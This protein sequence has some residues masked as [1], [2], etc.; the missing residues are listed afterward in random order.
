MYIIGL[1][2]GI[3]S[4][5]STVSKILKELGAKI[6]DTDQVAR[7]VV[8]PGQP[9]YKDIISNFGEGVLMPDGQLDRRALGN[10]VFNNAEAREILNS[11]THPRIREAVAKKIDT[12]RQ[13]NPDAVV[14]IEAPLLIEAGMDDMVD[15]IW[16]V[17]A[18]VPV[19]LK[20]LMARNRL[21]EE[22]A[23]SRLKSQAGDDFRLKY[24]DKV[25][26]TGGDLEG[27][28]QAVLRVWKEIQ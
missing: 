3:A 28:R 23:K 5:K 8:V 10:I 6:I 20:R 15:S 21:S 4:G 14:I 13:E 9:A 27:T 19:R 1:T 22:E 12:F 16:V 25:I 11:I 24:A 17:T 7:E 26:N 2:G 18:P